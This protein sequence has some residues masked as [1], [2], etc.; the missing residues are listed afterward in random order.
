LTNSPEFMVKAGWYRHLHERFG[1]G[2]LMQHES[3]RVTLDG[4]ETK[5]FTRFDLTLATRLL[6]GLTL[7]AALRNAFDAEIEYPGGAEHRQNTLRQDGRTFV[8]RLDARLR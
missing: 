8:L 6:P 5:G 4:T 3:G 1:A 7:N 2:M